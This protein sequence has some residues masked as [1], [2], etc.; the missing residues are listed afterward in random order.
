VF[1]HPGNE[2]EPSFD[3]ECQVG[4]GLYSFVLVSAGDAFES[5]ATDIRQFLVISSQPFLLRTSDSS[6]WPVWGSALNVDLDEFWLGPPLC[7]LARC[8][9]EERSELQL[10]GVAHCA[11]L[12]RG[13]L[14]G[15]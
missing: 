2:I 15:G 13:N 8:G 14:V 5:K 12:P 4:Q 1:V 11:S 9:G 10:R 3:L 6:N 7:R